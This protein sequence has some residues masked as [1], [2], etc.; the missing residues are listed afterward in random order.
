MRT[1]GVAIATLAMLGATALAADELPPSARSLAPPEREACA[2]EIRVLQNRR[3]LFAGQNLSETELRRR[4]AAAEGALA[5][6]VRQFREGRSRRPDRPA[7][8]GEKL[9][10]EEASKREQERR[11]RLDEAHR[12]DPRFMR[13]LL[14]AVI[15]YQRQKK[16]RAETGVDEENRFARLGGEPDRLKLYRYQSDLSRASRSLGIA[17]KEIAEYGAPLPCQEEKL[18]VL[19]HCLAV[20][21]GEAQRDEGCFAEEVRQYLRLL[22]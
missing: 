8:P 4:N 10:P 14:S 13:E 9:S 20:Q 18:A 12:R 3:R 1:S 21:D 22:R 16:E 2:D 6:C 7:N 19:A 11:Q 17:R 15:C 5:E